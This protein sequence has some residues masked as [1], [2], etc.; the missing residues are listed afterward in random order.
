MDESRDTPVTQERAGAS[1]FL[2][3][4]TTAA[5]ACLIT[6]SIMGLGAMGAL[7]TPGS[8]YADVAASGEVS[9][10]EPKVI[11]PVYTEADLAAFAASGYADDEL[12][13]AVVWGMTPEEARGKA[14]SK[15]LAGLPLPFGPDEATTFSYT[16][17][18][19]RMALQD[20]VDS[21]S[22]LI[23]LATVWGSGDIIQAKAE[24]GAALLAH[25][26]LPVVPATF[27]D[28][29]AIRAFTLAGYDDAAAVKLSGL[30]QID[31]HTAAVRAG[32]DILADKELPL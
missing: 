18:Q 6:G 26:P 14:G 2:R 8:S 17:D 12:N 19:Q 32:N 4:G 21:Y 29:Q 27:T 24:M 1:T 13:L 15:V 9:T 30:W 10:S 5:A 20:S 7:A 23:S 28:D 31:T 11:A 3:V 25:Q 22:E 16:P